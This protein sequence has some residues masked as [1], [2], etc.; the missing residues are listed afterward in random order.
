MKRIYEVDPLECPK[1]QAQMRILAFIQDAHSIK[2]I[3][4]SQAIPDFQAPSLIPKF[5][6]TSQAIEPPSYDL[7]DPFPD[8]SS[9]RAQGIYLR[10]GYSPT[11]TDS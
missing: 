2:D 4:K 9:Q 5:I 8:L 3:I 10:P 6:D 11:K 7:F 1:C